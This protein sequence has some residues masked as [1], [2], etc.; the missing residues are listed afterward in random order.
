MS[1]SSFSR[2]SKAV[3]AGAIAFLF[4]VPV[5]T[6]T[7]GDSGAQLTGPM[8]SSFVLAVNVTNTLAVDRPDEVM[9]L[10]LTLPDSV[11]IDSPNFTVRGQ[12]DSS[13]ALSGPL[14]S[15]VELY[16]SGYIHRMRIA[17]QDSFTASERKG[18]L[19]RAGERTALVGDMS[20]QV[21]PAWVIVTD[22]NATDERVYRLFTDHTSDNDPYLRGVRV[23]YYHTGYPYE[24]QSGILVRVAGDQTIVDQASFQMGWGTP[25]PIV[26]DVNNVMV[27]VNLVYRNP[28]AVQWGRGMITTLQ[29]DVDILWADVTVNFYNNRSMV[30]AYVSKK[31][32]EKFYNHNGFLMETSILL[33]GN[34]NYEYIFGTPEHTRQW[35]NTT[36][37]N[38]AQDATKLVGLDVGNRS[39][40]AAADLDDDRDLDLIVG[41]LNGTLAGFRNTGG[42]AN[43]IYTLDQSLVPAGGPWYNCT[44]PAIGDLDADGDLDLVVG[45]QIGM[46]IAF[47][48]VGSPAVPSWSRDDSL[49]AGVTPGP[50]AQPNAAPELA[51]LDNDGD[52][53][54]LVGHAGGTFSFYRNTGVPA[55]PA[56][57]EDDAEFAY[58]NN[59]STL[60]PGT[61]ATPEIADVNRDGKIDF[62]SGQ[63]Y[64]TMGSLV[65]FENE[66]TNAQ[67]RFTRL[68]PAM[69]NNV[70]GPGYYD[71]DYSVPE[72]GEFTGDGLEDIVTGHSDGTLLLWVN[73]GYTLP[74][75]HANT[76]QPLENGSYRFYYDQD[77]NDGQY[78]TRNYSSTFDGWYVV[79]NPSVNASILRYVPDF[80]RYVYRD[81]YSGEMYPW[82]GG[83]TS[84]YPFIPSEDGRITRGMLVT[85]VGLNTTNAPYG[86]G[87]TYLSQTGT[88]GGYIK[89]P[90]TAMDIKSHEALL[91]ELPYDPTA[92]LYDTLAA[93]LKNPL[94]IEAGP[95]LTLHSLDI[96]TDPTDPAEGAAA[97]I[98]AK[99]W[100]V[101]FNDSTNVQVE[102][103]NGD[104]MAGGVK[105]G[106]T[107]TILSLPAGGGA[108][109]SVFWNTVG[110]AGPNT[111][112]VAVDWAG[113]VSELDEDNN[114]A[115]RLFMV[116][117]NERLWSDEVM[118]SQSLYND[119][120]PDI[121]VDKMN[122]VWFAWHNF[123]SK[124]DYNV[125]ATYFDGTSWGEV[126]GIAEGYK[127]TSAPSLAPSPDGDVWLVFSSNLEEYNKFIAIKNGI[128]YW[129]MKFDLYAAKHSYDGWQA[130]ERVSYAVE[131]NNSDQTP[132]AEFTPDGKLWMT[133][134]HTHFQLYTNGYQMYN[135][136]YQDMNISA[137][138][139][140][141]T[142][143]SSEQNVDNR[144]GNQGWWGGASIAVAPNGTVW[145]IY[146]SEVGQ[147]QFDIYAKRNSGAGW[148][149]PIGLTTSSEQDIRPVATFDSSGKLWVAW[150]SDRFGN[151][152]IFVKSF[153]GTAWSSNIQ[154]TDDP[155]EDMKPAISANPSGYVF[156]AWE[157]DRNGNKDIFLKVYNTT[158]W[159]PDFQVTTDKHSDEHVKITNSQG[160]TW[161][162][163][164]SDRNGLGNKD[165][166][167]KAFSGSPPTPYVPR[168]GPS[169]LRAELFNNG[170]RDVMLTWN[171]SADDW[172]YGSVTGYVVRCGDTYSRNGTGYQTVVDT[173][174]GANWALIQYRGHNDPRNLFCHVFANTTAGLSA[175]SNQAGAWKVHLTGH[176][177]VSVPLLIDDTSAS[178][179]LITTT[180]TPSAFT[181]A[182]YYD[183]TDSSDPW[184]EYSANAYRDLFRID[185]GMGLWAGSSGPAQITV[186]GVVPDQ[187]RILLKAG[188][189]LVGYPSLTSRNVSDALAGLPILR[190]EGYDSSA[191]NYNLRVLSGN[192]LMAPGQGYWILVSSDSTWLVYA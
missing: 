141:G 143:W 173:P 51:D 82:A 118:I 28:F 134:R 35:G 86:S 90:M 175:P 98:S 92:A 101:G 163:W 159:S 116:T 184:K 181:Y 53:D 105:I 122:R 158:G 20:Y 126:E 113:L 87:G 64:T 89:A 164:E 42:P 37:L 110:K 77:G 25:E 124:E 63:G 4:I 48:N 104:P 125:Y 135:I 144:A 95:D 50:V 166:Y 108:T 187:Y 41:S 190:V 80:A 62:V 32:N 136:P 33:A 59:G 107:Q 15:S 8:A 128:Y 49:V 178:S 150:E 132:K 36:S 78:V 24:V 65:Y 6:R 31:V 46:V 47:R 182:R 18:Y 7:G 66:W 43:P 88:A 152:D 162:V 151:K 155:G 169:D 117:R 68:Y 145:A 70:R 58:L 17:F 186:A 146:E 57:S 85:R 75:R 94:R 96:T 188:W 176:N 160:A 79:S 83:N 10:N 123:A 165:I 138:V 1:R 177:L 112:F 115:S 174:P 114:I 71:K 11:I 157:G 23:Y 161:L 84:Y 54:L 179:V 106:T 73:K 19:I 121:V 3:W 120:D 170:Y 153:D 100:N 185:N 21:I 97:T 147:A 167:V 137:R 55:A 129:S 180:V 127:H 130:P 103:F 16:P 111:I 91:M 38:W 140:D 81:R 93:V 30:D 12:L 148:S 191:P 189:N 139:Y 149:A 5:S 172:L 109:A 44:F 67:P 60:K 39:A 76:M 22:G 69:F 168:R 133:F 40:P 45:T 183:S 2:V 61:Y 52:L 99:V 72:F 154:L 171:L 192:D 131:K 56:W 119:M 27:S 156:V 14:N 13:E 142:T 9:Q 74:E 26:V 29:K 34:G 102:F